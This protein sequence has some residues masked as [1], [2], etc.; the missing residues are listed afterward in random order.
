MWGAKAGR[1]DEG[2]PDQLQGEEPMG[3]RA[4]EPPSS[5]SSTLPIVQEMG[6]RVKRLYD[7]EQITN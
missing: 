6:G 4:D 1:R 3:M 5:S 7:G 2:R